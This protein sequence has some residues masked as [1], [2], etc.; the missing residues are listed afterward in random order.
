MKKFFPIFALLA[1]ALVSCDKD[2]SIF[3]GGHEEHIIEIANYT[4]YGT[5]ALPKCWLF[6]HS[7]V[8]KKS[9]EFGPYIVV[10]R[11]GVDPYDGQTIWYYPD[12]KWTKAIY[13]KDS[14]KVG[15]NSFKIFLPGKIDKKSLAK[16]AGEPEIT[17]TNTNAKW[18]WLSISMHIPSE[19]SDD[20]YA[21]VYLTDN[22]DPANDEGEYSYASF[23]YC[24]SDTAVSGEYTRLVLVNS[25]STYRTTVYENVTLKKG[26]NIVSSRYTSDNKLIYS[27]R[28]PDGA[29]WMICE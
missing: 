5:D 12:G 28:V 29:Q 7:Q 21:D 18:S 3:S 6:D 14:E 10:K 9:S 13:L 22:P 2:D 4:E 8:V 25:K 19:T 26:W 24:D 11:A 17:S 16:I 15:D 27:S 1:L 23:V 20:R